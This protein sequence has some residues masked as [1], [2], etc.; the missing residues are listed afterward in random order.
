M[1]RVVH[2][3]RRL[4][5]SAEPQR[6]FNWNSLEGRILEGGY[7]LQDCLGTTR[8][9]AT[10]RV[11]ILGD[12]F[13]NAVATVFAPETVPPEQSVIWSETL[14]LR[15]QHLNIPLALGELAVDG[16][17]VWY[18]IAV[19]PDETLESVLKERALSPEEAQVVAEAAV[20]ALEY[21]HENGFVHSALSPGEILGI[22]DSIRLSTIRLRRGNAPLPAA[23]FPPARYHAPES[24]GSGN[25]SRAADVYCLG[26]TLLEILTRRPADSASDA[27]VHTLPAPFNTLVECALNPD[28]GARCHLAEMRSILAGRVPD[29]LRP[30]PPAPD[31]VPPKAESAGETAA[32]APA[33]AVA[34]DDPVPL[35]A[36]AS[37]IHATPAQP[38]PQPVLTT[39]RPEPR[40]HVE[41]KTHSDAPRSSAYAPSR[42]AHRPARN[43]MDGKRIWIYGGAVIALIILG[44][45]FARD[46][47]TN[48]TPAQAAQAPTQPTW[49]THEVGP[50]NNT[51]SAPAHAAAAP[52]VR[53]GTP[54]SA[55]NANWRVIAYTFNREADAVRRVNAIKDKHPDLQPEVFSPSG[56]GAPY[57]VALGGPVSKEQA[58]RLRQR[59]RGAGMPRDTFIR[60]YR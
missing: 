28:P 39:V 37:A 10:Y 8:N 12:R 29:R 54:A 17:A 31:P 14:E 23:P 6:T 45:L 44:I 36:A 5:M 1:P 43:A 60:N 30:A 57:L 49:P 13:T 2:P 51:A 19:A 47:G 3:F 58:E 21:L 46:H 25:I 15:H 56:H 34:P 22:G 55:G 26:A 59:A 48:K 53:Q 24:S 9:N 32:S 18:V 20:D 4:L 41:A 52:A 11:R 50:V 7:E 27:R 42:P 40:R 38:K 16:S 33:R 35:T